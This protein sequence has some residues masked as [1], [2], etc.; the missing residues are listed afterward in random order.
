MS[1][2]WPVWRLIVDGLCLAA[3]GIPLLVIKYSLT[4]SQRGFYCSDTSLYYP[5]LHSTIPTAVNVAV[6]Q[7][8]S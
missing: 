8:S 2:R 6:R 7:D 4:P 5:Y 1:E 3:V